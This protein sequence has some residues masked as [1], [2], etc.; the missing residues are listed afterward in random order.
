MI[1]K[2]PMTPTVSVAGQPLNTG[3]LIDQNG[4]YV[5]Y[6][7]LV[8]E[9]MYD[10]IVQ[11]GLYSKAGQQAFTQPI[12]FSFGFSARLRCPK[13]NNKFRTVGVASR[14]DEANIIQRCFDAPFRWAGT[15]FWSP[16]EKSGSH[17]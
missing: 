11:N 17:T 2:T 6:Q 3:P 9:P 7:I 1:S 13:N 5:R 14:A 4:H 8:N 12:S 16:P 15:R 10:Y